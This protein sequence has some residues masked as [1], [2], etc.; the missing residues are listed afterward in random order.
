MAKPKKKQGMRIPYIVDDLGNT[1]DRHAIDV[2]PHS[3]YVPPL[4]CKGC[5]IPVSARSSNADDPDSRSS[6]YFKLPGRDHAPT[7][8]YDLKRRGKHLV[9]TSQGTVIRRDGQWRLKCPPLE[10]P[11]TRGATKGPSGPARP[12]WGGGGSGTRPTSKLRGPAI[13]SARRILQLL[14]DFAHD[15]EAVAEFAAVAPGGQQN[16]PWDEF[17]FGR[18]RVD[19]LAQALI[20][21]SARQIPHAVWGPASTTDAVAG[22]TGESYVVKYVARN[23]V[24]VD[25]RRIKLQVALRC[26]NPEWIAVASRSGQFLGY[27]YWTLFP[28]DLAK[29]GERGWIELQL[30]VKEPWQAE[31]WDVSETP[32]V[33]PTPRRRPPSAGPVTVPSS[34]QV[35]T[36]PLDRDP[37]DVPDLAPAPATATD[38]PPRDSTSL[39]ARRQPADLD[40][41]P[42]STHAREGDDGDPDRSEPVH[43]QG[44]TVAPTPDNVKEPAPPRTVADSTPSTQHGPPATAQPP[45]PSGPPPGRQNG[46]IPFPPPPSHPP[47]VAPPPSPGVRRP[48]VR[49]WLD[50]LRRR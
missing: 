49:R 17:C 9:D 26:K 45:Q 48:Q 30:W 44:S 31:R 10:R 27:G 32:S 22:K 15:P 36:R 5:G 28:A 39:P 33:L 50:R 29:A 25:G 43:E 38:P 2:R 41:T 12:P 8:T 40:S 35:P 24:T 46:G 20:D 23:P 42:V 7:C 11:G 1:Y 47:A 37:A 14:E 4:K 3:P 19:Q 6:H 21:G 13:A 34:G 18:G 16:I